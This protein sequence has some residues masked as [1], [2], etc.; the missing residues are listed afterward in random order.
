MTDRK[1]FIHTA[2]CFAGTEVMA[3]GLAA[4]TEIGRP[5]VEAI[6]A[7]VAQKPEANHYHRDLETTEKLWR[8]HAAGKGLSPDI[9]DFQFF[10]DL[11]PTKETAALATEVLGFD[12]PRGAYAAMTAALCAEAGYQIDPFSDFAREIVAYTFEMKGDDVVDDLMAEAADNMEAKAVSQHVR[13]AT[14]Q[15]AP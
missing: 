5:L 10:Q 2:Q 8:N 12:Y 15:R 7:G 14:R 1:G 13:A 4:A 3:S 11:Y 6:R 9:I